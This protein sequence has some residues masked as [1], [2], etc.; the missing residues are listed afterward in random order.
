MEILEKTKKNKIKKNIKNK[1]KYIL[2]MNKLSLK[3]QNQK[4]RKD[5]E[6][7]HKKNVFKKR[8]PFKKT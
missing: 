1:K 6:M 7:Q 3:E 4:L 8:D 5:L 2:I